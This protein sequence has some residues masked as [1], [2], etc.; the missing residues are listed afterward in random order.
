MFLDEIERGAQEGL[1]SCEGVDVYRLQGQVQ[2]LHSLKGKMQV[3]V[4][5]IT[6]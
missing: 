4:D 1:L 2:V 5:K 6:L 3:V